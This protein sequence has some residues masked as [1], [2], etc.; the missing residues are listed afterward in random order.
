MLIL[1]QKQINLTFNPSRTSQP[2]LSSF[3]VIFPKQYQSLQ[4]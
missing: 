1:V 2:M 3:T 4:G